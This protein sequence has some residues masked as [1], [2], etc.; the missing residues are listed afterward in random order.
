[1]FCLLNN[2]LDRAGEAS[3]DP[4]VLR[5]SVHYVEHLL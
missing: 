2:A 4:P 1:M 3:Y 5:I